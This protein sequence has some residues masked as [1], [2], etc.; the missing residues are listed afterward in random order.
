MLTRYALIMLLIV[1]A[2]KQNR[3]VDKPPIERD[4]M[5]QIMV[6]IHLLEAQ[7]QSTQI[8]E[9]GR[10]YNTIVGYEK[11]FGKHGVTAEQFQDTFEYYRDHPKEMDDL[12]QLVIDE[13]TRRESE[14]SSKAAEERLKKNPR[15]TSKPKKFTHPAL[16]RQPVIKEQ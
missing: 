7:Q 16:E 10:V 12:Y 15:D 2:C 6:D 3:K 4:K 11:I 13:V 9:K 8:L 14:I 5:V 1:S